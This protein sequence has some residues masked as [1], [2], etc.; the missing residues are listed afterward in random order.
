MKVGTD[1]K[2]ETVCHTHHL[3]DI[4][5]GQAST[6]SLPCWDKLVV[7]SS[8]PMLN[9]ITQWGHPEAKR[10]GVHKNQIVSLLSPQQNKTAA[11]L[12]QNFVKQRWLC[13]HF[14]LWPMT[15]IKG[16]NHESPFP[17]QSLLSA[18]VKDKTWQ[19]TNMKAEHNPTDPIRKG[20]CIWRAD[21]RTKPSVQDVSAPPGK[22][23]VDMPGE[24]RKASHMLVLPPPPF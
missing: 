3:C 8:L 5:C 11:C 21:P 14:D 7:S 1:D 20:C 23:W 16:R 9:K 13:S 18:C 17:S 4:L 15:Q 22:H 10:I 19:E 12:Q 24:G 6:L 2:G